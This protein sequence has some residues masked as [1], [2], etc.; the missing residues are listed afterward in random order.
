[1]HLAYHT[2]TLGH[3][4]LFVNHTRSQFS[5]VTPEV[6]SESR[7][8]DSSLFLLVTAFAHLNFVH[9]FYIITTWHPTKCSQFNLSGTARQ[10]F[11][12]PISSFN[13]L[14]EIMCHVIKAPFQDIQI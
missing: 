7:G 6:V 8:K 3:R 14:L 12:E 2:H 11:L 13:D 5:Q 10:K 1:M 9:L 4:A